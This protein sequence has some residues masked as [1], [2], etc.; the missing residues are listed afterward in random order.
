MDGRT[1]TGCWCPEEGEQGQVAASSP[2]HGCQDRWGR[3]RSCTGGDSGWASGE[4]SLL[5]GTMGS[6]G[7]GLVPVCVTA[8]WRHLGSALM[9]CFNGHCSLRRPLKASGHSQC[10]C[11]A[12]QARRGR[13]PLRPEAPRGAPVPP[14]P[15][16]V[17][18]DRLP[19]RPLREGRT[20]R[21]GAWTRGAGPAQRG[22][23]RELGAW[24]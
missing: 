14:Q 15:Q 19:Q 7:R 8:L 10:T 11:P 4:I 9:R 6:V 16:G 5:Q 23:G 1:D 17:P 24:L 13:V 12:L 18:G 3:A 21:G 22:R 2:G 20:E